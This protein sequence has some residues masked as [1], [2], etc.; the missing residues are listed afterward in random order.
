MNRVRELRKKSGYSQQELAALLV[1]IN[2]SS[3][4][5]IE[6]GRQGS[7]SLDN[8]VQL[9]RFFNVTVDYLIGENNAE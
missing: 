6:R 4:S 9:S 7:N 5:Q 1:N 2:Q 3:L 8:M